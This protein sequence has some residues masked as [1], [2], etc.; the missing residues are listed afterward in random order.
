[1]HGMEYIPDKDKA[2]EKETIAYDT[3]CEISNG[4]FIPIKVDKSQ[5]DPRS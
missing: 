2:S 1:M 4:R 5:R 3:F